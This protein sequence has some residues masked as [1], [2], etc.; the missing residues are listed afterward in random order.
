ML[1]N[2]TIP[3][4]YVEHGNVD[5]LRKEVEIDADSIVK[6]ILELV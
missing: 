1:I 3:D 5:I 6:R 4:E 2:V